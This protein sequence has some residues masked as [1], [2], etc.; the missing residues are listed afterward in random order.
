MRGG[1]EEEINYASIIKVSLLL[2]CSA[3]GNRCVCTTCACQCFFVYF[4]RAKVKLAFISSYVLCEHTVRVR[5]YLLEVSR[6]CVFTGDHV[7]EDGDGGLPQL[8]F[9]DQSH[10]QDG[11]HHAG[12]ETDLMAA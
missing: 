12:D 6:V 4:V 1:V 3:T 11:T 8:F 7:E 10:L 9:W 2:S 5:F